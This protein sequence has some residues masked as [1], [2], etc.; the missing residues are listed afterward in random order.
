MPHSASLLFLSL[1]F[2]FYL[3]LSLWF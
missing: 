3:F 1:G 2:Y